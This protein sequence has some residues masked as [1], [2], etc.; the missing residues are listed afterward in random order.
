MNETQGDD[1]FYSIA[2]FANEL[3]LID[4]SFFLTSF[5]ISKGKSSI[6]TKRDTTKGIHASFTFE[7]CIN[8]AIQSVSVLNASLYL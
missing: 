7:K 8:I 5:R 3:G 4:F 1:L 6:S 2:N